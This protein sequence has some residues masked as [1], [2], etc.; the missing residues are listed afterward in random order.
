MY[1]THL[2]KRSEGA[3]HKGLL[4]ASG[5]IAGEAIAGI[6]IAIPRTLLTGIEIPIPL[7]DSLWLSLAALAAVMFLIDR[8]ASR[9]SD[10]G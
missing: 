1:N 9:S 7:V 6:L 10:A 4:I 3:R 2:Q 5:L 8:F